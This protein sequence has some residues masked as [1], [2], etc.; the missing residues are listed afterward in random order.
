MRLA[1]VYA[2]LLAGAFAVIVA[3]LGCG[4]TVRYVTVEQTHYCIAADDPPPPRPTAD[5]GVYDRESDP[6][7]CKHRACLDDAPYEAITYYLPRADTWMAR[8]WGPP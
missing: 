5:G 2:S 7:G 6:T 3:T 4:E 1:V 8:A